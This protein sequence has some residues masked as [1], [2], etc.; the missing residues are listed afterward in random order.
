MATPPS[1]KQPSYPCPGCGFIV[2]DEPTGSYDICPLCNWEDDHVQLANPGM[3]GGANGESLYEHQLRALKHLPIQFK[4]RMGYP[5]DPSWR[6]LRP[7]ECRPNPNAPTS[8]QEYF[9][10]AVKDS[11]SYYWKSDGGKV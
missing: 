5:R 4:E 6:P 1:P 8:G 11:P 2:F 10:A 7:E 3:G 9:E